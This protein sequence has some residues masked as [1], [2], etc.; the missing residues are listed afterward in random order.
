MD[1]R[2][3]RASLVAFVGTLLLLAAL[4]S[5]ASSTWAT[6]EQRVRANDDTIPDKACDDDLLRR[7]DSSDY[8][9]VV[10]HPMSPTDTWYDTVLTDTIDA[11]LQITGLSTTRGYAAWTDHQVTFTLGTMVPGDWARLEIHFTL[12]DDAPFGYIVQNVAYMHHQ[13]WDWIPSEPMPV[14]FTVGYENY[15]P[16]SLRP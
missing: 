10:S 7:G 11:N 1:Q 16:L 3:K 6:P 14:T 15:M 4:A 12:K 5:M 8:V 9:I 13:G 2:K